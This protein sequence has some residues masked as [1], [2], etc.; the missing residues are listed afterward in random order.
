[1]RKGILSRSSVTPLLGL[2]AVLAAVVLTAPARAA[3]AGGAG[4][5]Q[6]GGAGAAQVGGA[7]AAQVG[8]AGAAQVGGAGAAQA[9][10]DRVLPSGASGREFLTQSD[11]A[12]PSERA[13][14]VWAQRLARFLSFSP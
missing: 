1:M 14:R 11:L 4:A 3:Q 12:T 10:D 9:G 6:V 7:G 13:A 5:A 2:A 8:G